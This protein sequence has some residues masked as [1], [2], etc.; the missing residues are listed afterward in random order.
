[1]PTRWTAPCRDGLGLRW[2]FMGPFQTIDL[3][4]KTGIAEYCRNLGPMYHGLAKEQ[5][6][7]RAWSPELVDTIE[8]QLRQRT[9]A[10]AIP[11]RQRWRDRV[12]AKLGQFQA[13]AGLTASSRSG[14]HA[15]PPAILD[16]PQLTSG[17][18]KAP[19]GPWSASN[20]GGD[21]G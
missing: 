6:D 18:P 7:P 1:M 8:R 16:F 21:R 15:R 19:R 2:S 4:A 3:N 13:R 17:R 11:A 10:E 9:P 12:L 14:R 5:A 20:G